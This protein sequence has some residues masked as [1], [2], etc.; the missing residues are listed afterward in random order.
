MTNKEL[1]EYFN[2]SQ[3]INYSDLGVKIHQYLSSDIPHKV[4]TVVELI[5]IVNELDWELYQYNEELQRKPYSELYSSIISAFALNP[6]LGNVPPE[7]TQLDIKLRRE[8]DTDKITLI[9]DK[10]FIPLMLNLLL[11]FNL[12]KQLLKLLNIILVTRKICLKYHKKVKLTLDADKFRRIRLKYRAEVDYFGFKASFT[13][14]D[15]KAAYRRLSLK[16]HPDRGGDPR[17][18]IKMKQYYDTLS[19]LFE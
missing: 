10:T 2:L 1:I 14:D 13:E 18:F 17:E 4:D 12:D 16:L 6:S 11:K 3:N 15:L 8:D 7:L 19:K 9:I 5:G